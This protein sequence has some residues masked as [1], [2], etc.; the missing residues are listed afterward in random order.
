[1]KYQSNKSLV[2]W[3]MRHWWKILLVTILLSIGFLIL[4]DCAPIIALVICGIFLIAFLLLLVLFI[5]FIVKRNWKMVIC[6]FLIGIVMFL[7]IQIPLGILDMYDAFPDRFGKRHPIPEGLE[8]NIPITDTN[9]RWNAHD[10]FMFTPVE[11]DSTDTTTWLQIY[12]GF[13]GGIY[14]YSFYWPALEDGIIYLRC[15]EASENIELSADRL[16]LSTKMLVSGHN[17]FG[18]VVNTREFTIYEGDWEDYYAVRVEVWHI[19]YLP[20]G[21]V[22]NKLM[23][24]IYRMEGWMR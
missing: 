22:E 20:T 16:L 11:I 7:F 1:M 15:F 14:H 23:Q 9:C 19:S 2:Q 17:E 18:Q 5:V 12:D 3:L 13:Q 8:V 21:Q 10:G 4:F 24:K 6:S